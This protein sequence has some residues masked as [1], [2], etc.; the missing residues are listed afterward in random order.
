METVD[1]SA[2]SSCVSF[3]TVPATQSVQHK[4]L[5]KV[6]TH[7]T[8]NINTSLSGGGMQTVH[9]MSPGRL[10]ECWMG[11]QAPCPPAP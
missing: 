4:R 9:K 7:Q 5:L 8:L 11:L 10:V 2:G 6:K 1:R 3:G